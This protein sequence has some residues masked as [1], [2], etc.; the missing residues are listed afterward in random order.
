MAIAAALLAIL[1][2][3]LIRPLPVLAT[4]PSYDLIDQ[5]GQPTRDTDLRGRIILYDFIYTS[6][7]TV[8]PVMTGQMLQA[9][10]ALA[11]AGWLGGEVVLVSV[12]FDP[13]RDTPAR[14]REYAAQMH[15]RPDGWLW[16]TGDLIAIKQLVGGEFGVYF[17]KVGAG[18]AGHA[19]HGEVEAG[20]DF[21]HDT[22]F[23]LVD[24]QGRLRAEYHQFPGQDA[25]M[26]DIGS[27][28][29][30]KN[31]RGPAR[32]VWQAAHWLSGDAR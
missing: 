8:C 15:T 16:L 29:R 7:T 22:T 18:E 30:E 14:L 17:E 9:Q 31:A 32:L 2:L 19:M 1:G 23:A 5:D 11:D 20:Y 25:I 12:T 6:C 10:T 27:L 28:V 13:E 4:A 26:R 3:A 24:D 21:V